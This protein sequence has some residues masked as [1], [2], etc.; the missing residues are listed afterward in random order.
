M[1]ARLLEDYPWLTLDDLDLEDPRLTPPP[2]R[3]A[4][5]AAA[6][7]AGPHVLEDGDFEDEALLALREDLEAVRERWAFEGDDVGTHVYTHQAGGR[8]TQRFRGVVTDAAH[9]KARAH[10]SEFCETF[11][12]PKFKAFLYTTHGQDGANEL[13][14]EWCRKAHFFYTIWAESEGGEEFHDPAVHEYI[15]SDPFHRIRDCH[16]PTH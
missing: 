14:R 15:A 6:A 13:A 11:Q 1:L 8:W 3:A 7:A 12:W 2:R 5:P 16:P 9:Y 10:T 4:A